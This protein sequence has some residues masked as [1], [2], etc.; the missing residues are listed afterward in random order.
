MANI[1]EDLA[2]ILSSRYGK[3]VRQAIHDSI[4]D[5]NEIA[6][7]Q[8]SKILEHTKDAEAWGVGTKDGTPV[9]ES[10]KQ[11]HNNA[12][13][14]SEE[15]NRLGD[16]QAQNAEAWATGAKTG[17]PVDE[18]DPTYQNNAKYY[19][20]QSLSFANE[21]S[22]YAQDSAN[23]ADQSGA[24]AQNSSDSADQASAYAGDAQAKATAASN[25]ADEAEEWYNKAK[26]IGEAVETGIRPMGSIMFADLP[27]AA[28]SEVGD[29]YHI[30]DNFT[31]TS[32]FADGGGV[33]YPAACEVYLTSN[34]KW[35]IKDYSILTQ[36]LVEKIVAVTEMYVE[37]GVLYLPNTAASVSDKIL[38]L[39]VAE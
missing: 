36:E 18:E 11:Y 30:I 2:K 34:N 27:N 22:R 5:I 21:S 20:E 10:D 33:S 25:S 38:I 17:E 24:Y 8:E 16:V 37:N 26:A 35:D 31:S 19:S 1:V 9:G 23:S 3:D 15:A 4:Y 12:K 39:G 6:E 29:Q 7:G 28:D 32:D 14:Y 13:Y